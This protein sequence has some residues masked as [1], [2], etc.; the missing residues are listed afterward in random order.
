MVF[1]LPKLMLTTG[2]A[3][4]MNLSYAKKEELEIKVQKTSP[5][6][7]VKTG[8]FLFL[9]R[10]S[11]HRPMPSPAAPHLAPEGP[12]H[13]LSSSSVCST[14]PPSHLDPLV[15]SLLCLY[16]WF[17]AL[18]WL[19]L[20]VFLNTPPSHGVSFALLPPLNTTSW[21]PYHLPSCFLYPLNLAS[22]L[23]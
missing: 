11:T 15:Y 6:T 22:K 20:C 9:Q 19:F 12:L 18:Y 23:P 16:F 1:K 4:L 8:C 2:K 10:T 5:F 17:L 21:L 14:L 7:Q 13:L 3:E